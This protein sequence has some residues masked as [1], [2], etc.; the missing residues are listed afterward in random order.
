MLAQRTRSRN[1]PWLTWLV[2]GVAVVMLPAVIGTGLSA[3]GARRWLQLGSFILH[4][5]EM[6][7]LGL[8]LVLAGVLTNT[9]MRVH[10][11]VAVALGLA[12][13]PVALTLLQPDLSTS[14]L[15]LVVLM[16]SLSQAHKS[17]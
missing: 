5:S 4:P 10:R 1:W 17:R 14:S 6:A 2:Y 8:L 12:A 7:K 11:R 15:L 3:Y 9:H 13:V 16:A